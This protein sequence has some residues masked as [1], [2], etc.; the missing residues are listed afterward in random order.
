MRA[1]KNTFRSLMTQ[2]SKKD[3]TDFFYFPFI[4]NQ[5]NHSLIGGIRDFWGFSGI[6]KMT[7]DTPERL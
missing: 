3:Y 7:L 4:P 5:C 2:I 6:S 1:L